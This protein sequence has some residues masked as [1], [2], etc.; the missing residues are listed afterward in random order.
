MPKRAAAA[1]RSAAWFIPDRAISQVGDDHL[2]HASV[3]DIL[4]EAIR[5]ATAPATIGL[6]GGFGKGKSSTG[7]LVI[8]KFDNDQG[9]DVVRVSADKHSGEARA[10]NLV[11]SVAGEVVGRGVDSGDVEELARQL[12]ESTARAALDPTDTP[13]NRLIEGKYDW[14]DLLPTTIAWVA[15][16]LLALVFFVGAIVIQGGLGYALAALTSVPLLVIVFVAASK[17]TM[18][19]I[20]LLLTPGLRTDSVPRAEAADDVELVFAALVDLHRT[21][22]KRQLVV[23]VNDVDRLAP[24]P[25]RRAARDQVAAGGPPG[26]GADLRAGL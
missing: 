11:H 4:V 20:G 16:A 26:K 5:G 12:R 18:R 24:G 14:R 10:R 13:L 9:F 21:Q 25:A 2:D 19:Q 15:A 23:I 7:N 3:A 8:A 6:L 22:R 1:A 17:G